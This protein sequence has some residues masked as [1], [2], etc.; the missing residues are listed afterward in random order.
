[1][2]PEVSI[3]I[4][5]YN[6]AH[7]LKRAIRSVLQQSYEDF[8]LIVIDDG[9]TDETKAVV[10]AFEDKRLRYVRQQNKGAAAALNLG[11]RE[12]RSR[13]IAFLDDDDEWLPDK[14]EVQMDMFRSERM[15]TGVVYTGRWRVDPGSNEKM[16]Y[17]PDTIPK[18]NGDLHTLLFAHVTFV[19]LVTAV[20]RKECFEKVGGFDETL[21][22]G[23]DRDLWIRISRHFEFRF[24]PRAFVNVYLTP[25]SMSRTEANII[26]A[27]IMLLDRYDEEYRRYG[28]DRYLQLACRVGTSLMARREFRHGWRYLSRAIRTARFNVFRLA[29]MIRYGIGRAVKTR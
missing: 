11:I 12:A 24:I 22:S 8:E 15:K 14:L 2:P 10:R 3:L 9:S 20:I 19:C 5:T 17:P 25:D 4:P 13:F 28:K 7:V 1:M 18:M 27:H 21:P 29:P 6:R 23:N 26:K 16:Y